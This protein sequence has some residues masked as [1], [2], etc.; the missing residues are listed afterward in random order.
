MNRA[1]IIKLIV[2]VGVLG[3]VAALGGRRLIAW[4]TGGDIGE[5][6]MSKME[7]TNAGPFQIEA[8]LR[9]DPPKE[10]SN[11]L[12]IQLGDQA[13]KPVEH[14]EVAATYVMPAMGSMQEMRGSATVAD[15]GDGRYEAR[16]DLPMGGSWTLEV[17]ATA[18]GKTGTARFQITVGTSGL[19]ALGGGGSSS[20]PS[21]VSEPALAP[22]QLPAPALAALRDAI[23]ATERVRAELAAD[24]LDGAATPAR[25]ATQAIRAAQTALNNERSEVA[26]CL[27][28]AIAAGEQ[29]GG[30][31]DL[32]AARRAFGEMNRFLIAL[33]AADPRLQE[34]WHVFRCPMA[35]G[36][37]KWIQRA[38]TLEN[39]Y[40][41]EAMPTCGSEAGWGIAPA[42]DAEVSHEGHGHDG[43]DT[44][45]YTCSMHP[46]V[47]Q[48]QP[49][50]CPICSMNVTDVTYDEEESGTIFVDQGRRDE[51]GVRTA[52]VVRAPMSRSIRAVGR[53]AYDEKRLEDVTLKLGGFISK[54]YV[55]ET[56]QAVKKGQ[57]LFTLYSPEL[58][59]AQQEYLIAREGEAA[60]NGGRGGYL[61]RAAEKKLE[62]WGMPHGQLEALAR[63]GTPIEDV[64]F[65]APA[66]GYVIEKNVVEGASVTVGQRL[67]RIAALDRVWVEAEVYEADL[68]L[69]EKG[70]RALVTLSYLPDKNFEGKV[71]YVYPYLDPR[72]R[73]GRVRIEL[74]ND[75]L[76]LKPE[77]YAS[78]ALQ[79]ELGPRLQIPIG[80]VVYTGPRRLVFVDIGE[81][82]LRP[83]EVTLGARNEDRV[84]V[85]RGLR[86]GQHVVASGNF[87]IAAESRI[88]SNAK[89]WTEERAGETGAAKDAGSGEPALDPKPSLQD[90]PGMK[91]GSGR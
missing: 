61:V 18:G 67:F 28:H 86:E 45:Y 3:L 23:A 58:Y 91:M 29:L 43:K 20:K 33:G 73:T 22:L 19:R 74:P 83:Q 31:K 6:A 38:P 35:E 51:L 44:S 1:K 88:R 16:F 39:P 53:I 11:T 25:D 87:L 72:S 68:P 59:A 5:G 10:N 84:E 40:M 2:I 27:G 70:Q 49:G 60:A 69:V 81:G 17:K 34:G 78:V 8:G 14:A 37:K 65:Y 24:R 54:L 82:R 26:D 90:M 48:T 77:M 64:P 7:R 80:A 13:G 79:V 36:F 47:R 63:R 46:S 52:K 85:I 15:K 76:E 30:A 71:A 42:D 32:A 41:G 50:T 57:V 75:K 66:S 9:P 21:E 4:F 89:F 56:G 62:L 55:S 12:V